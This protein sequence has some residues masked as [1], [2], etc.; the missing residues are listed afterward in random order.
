MNKDQR[1]ENCTCLGN[2]AF[3]EGNYS[4]V[5]EKHTEAISLRMPKRTPIAE[6]HW[7]ARKHSTKQ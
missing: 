3:A 4:L 2:S 5:I 1:A 6:M 7:P